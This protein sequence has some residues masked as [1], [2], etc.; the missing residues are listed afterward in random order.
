[1][2]LL[3][4]T[5][6]GGAGKTTV[7]AATAALAARRGVKTLVVS[8][9]PAHS[10]T[11]ALGLAPARSTGEP[12]EVTAGLLVH[13][14]DP[15]T[16]LQRSWRQVQEWLLALLDQAGVDRVTAEELTVLPGATD[17]LALLEVRELTRS[18]GYDLVVLDGAPSGETLRLLA[19]PDLLRWWL[20]R[21]LPVEHRLARALRAPRRGPL[22]A[23]DALAAVDRLQADLADA[24]AVLTHP[25]ASVRL[26]VSP[27][28]LGVAEARRTRAA[29]ALHG[30]RVD[31]VVVNR[32][33][34]AGGADPWRTA[35]AQAQ[36]RHLADAAASFG[37]LPVLHAPYQAAEP[38]GVA[39]LTHFAESV[40]ADADP[41]AAPGPDA[42]PVV[43]SETGGG[44]RLDVPLPLVERADL[45]LA[46][47]G[48]DLVIT[49]GPHRRLLALPAA[50]RRCA[51]TGARLADGRLEVSFWPDP[52]QWWDR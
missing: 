11:D 35:L 1:M 50:L 32:V 21:L 31:G 18:G 8:A 24:R 14:V 22:G 38:V 37:P 36:Q 51:V 19:L 48:P 47:S 25:E 27:E 49:V 44:Y 12:V 16:R 9:D 42:S 33:V 10:L 41:L 2:R 39:A 46:R 15:R 29:L 40:Y 45:Q 17:V 5:G 26:V 4:V 34:P 28:A 6:K 23:L 13:E 30:Y 43:R 3:V 52:D 7:A 20:D